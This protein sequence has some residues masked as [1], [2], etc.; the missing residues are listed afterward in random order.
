MKVT[1]EITVGGAK[2]T[3]TVEDE[4]VTIDDSERCDKLAKL[5]GQICGA[6]Q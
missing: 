5:L 1:Q 6:E 3:I 2:V 4:T